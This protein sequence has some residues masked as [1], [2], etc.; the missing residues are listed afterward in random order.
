[1][2]AQL[3]RQYRLSYQPGHAGLLWGPPAGTKGFCSPCSLFV[4]L[5]PEFQRADSSSYLLKREET[6]TKEKLLQETISV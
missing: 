5:P 6:E 2:A 1:M 4:G 3:K